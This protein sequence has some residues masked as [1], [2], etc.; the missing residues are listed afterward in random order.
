MLKLIIFSLLGKKIVSTRVLF[1]SIKS[2]LIVY[3]L[4]LPA[5]L[6]AGTMVASVKESPVQPVEAF[7]E[8]RRL[9]C[10]AFYR[11][12]IDYEAQYTWVACLDGQVS[13]FLSG[14]MD[15]VRQRVR[16]ASRILPSVVWR[17]L[18][19]RYKLGDKTWRYARAMVL[20]ILRREYPHVDFREYPAHLHVNVDAN[21]RGRGYGRRLMSAYLEQIRGLDVPGVFLDTTNL[22]EAACRL[23]EKTGF[24]LL[25]VRPTRVWSHLVDQPVENRSYG[26]KL[27]GEYNSNA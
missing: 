20:G 25:D 3:L 16:F 24:H 23:S 7:L 13:G 21:I 27:V 10:D 18:Q 12:Y 1:N 22:N 4:I 26:L 15:T 8:D 14:S 19:G 9:F 2:Y 5:F 11:Y 17:A 6:S